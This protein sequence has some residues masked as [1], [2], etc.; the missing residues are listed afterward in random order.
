ME[1][2]LKFYLCIKQTIKQ[3][4]KQLF[5]FTKVSFGY[6]FQ[7]HCPVLN[8]HKSNVLNEAKLF[9]KPWHDRIIPKN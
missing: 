3:E 2:Y 9:K 7:K 5:I 1:G 4:I 6:H 8:K